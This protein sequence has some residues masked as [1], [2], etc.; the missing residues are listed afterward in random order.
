MLAPTPAPRVA[1]SV[2][3]TGGGVNLPEAGREDSTTEFCS[4]TREF[5]PHHRCDSP[6]ITESMTLSSDAGTSCLFPVPCLFEGVWHP[7][8]LT[9]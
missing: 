1:R 8:F 2:R 5:S 6:R 9:S 4:K 7:F 3:A